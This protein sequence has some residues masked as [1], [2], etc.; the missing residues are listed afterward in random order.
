MFTKIKSQLNI[1]ALTENIMKTKR[2]Y[3]RTGRN[4]QGKFNYSHISTASYSTSIV[5]PLPSL[6]L[7]GVN[8]IINKGIPFHLI[9]WFIQP[10]HLSFVCNKTSHCVTVM[11]WFEGKCISSGSKTTAAAS[12]AK[13][14]PLVSSHIKL[15]IG[16]IFYLD[17][18]SNKTTESLERDIKELGGVRQ[19][20]ILGHIYDFRKVEIAHTHTHTHS[21]NRVPCFLRLLKS[22][23]A[24]KLS[25]W[26]PIRRRL[27]MW[28]AS[29]RRVLSPAQTQG[30]VHP[31]LARTHTSLPA[32]EMSSKAD[33]WTQRT[34]SVY[35]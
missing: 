8:P 22:S 13:P 21:N 28:M 10:F 5:R 27:D 33:L 7:T 18:P 1:V 19:I 24:R 9:D 35:F 11:A 2:T 26:F 3:R 23:L 14:S 12:Q 17:L 34:R 6:K 20:S 15:L 29:D 30:R 32:T 4:C 16:K 25:I 31:I